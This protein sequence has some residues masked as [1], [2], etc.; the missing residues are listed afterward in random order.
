MRLEI[1][2]KDKK[3]Y[4]IILF[5]LFELLRA[6]N[7]GHWIFIVQTLLIVGLIFSYELSRKIMIIYLVL[8]MLAWMNWFYPLMPAPDNEILMIGSS[9]SLRF[10]IF[11]FVETCLL[12]MMLILRKPFKNSNEE[13]YTN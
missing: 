3:V 10:L 5:L 6:I 12:L 7:H 2:Q 11:L 13:L 8:Q 9:E 1:F 4:I